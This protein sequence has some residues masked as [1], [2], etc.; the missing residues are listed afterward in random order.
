[1]SKTELSAG[2]V[3]VRD[4]EVLL[5][6]DRYGRWTFPKGHL[7]AG[8]TDRQAAAREVREETGLNCRV[9]PRLGSVNYSLPNG[10]DK[11]VAF[12]LLAYL[13]GE[14]RVQEEEVDEARW[15]SLGE[16]TELLR[17]KGYPGYRVLLRRAVELSS[18]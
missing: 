12:Y 1:M 15:W 3:V 10:N 8:E 11:R 4:G 2:G 13:D 14:V 6:R 5:I 9:G 7:E 17:T 16:A 18:R